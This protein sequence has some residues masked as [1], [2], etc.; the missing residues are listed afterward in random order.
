MWAVAPRS[1]RS[2]ITG[3]EQGVLRS[4]HADVS[5]PREL[6]ATILNR[7]RRFGALEP[8][9]RVSDMRN[10]EQGTFRPTQGVR[11]GCPLQ[12]K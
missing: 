3:K 6:F 1:A 7:F 11:G 8:C 10:V 12:P 9:A 4:R 2:Q 5:A